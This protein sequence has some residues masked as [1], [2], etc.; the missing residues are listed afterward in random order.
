M[1]NRREL[2]RNGLAASALGGLP[3]ASA[4][5]FPMRPSIWIV[6]TRLAG[7]AETAT[8]VSAGAFPLLRFDSDP[9]SLWMREIE[10]ALR[11]GPTRIA[12]FTSAP[13]L[14]CLQYLAR[15]YGLILAGHAVGAALPQA[16]IHNQ[17]ALIDLR[18]PRYADPA[19]AHTWLLEPQRG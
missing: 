3:L 8:A 13:T 2:L 10:P 9:G 11:A 16:V 6:D 1:L 7:A 19:A 17:R 15:D 14:F 5:A 12:G 4:I 18:D